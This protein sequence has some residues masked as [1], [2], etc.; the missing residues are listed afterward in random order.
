[1]GIRQLELDV[2]YFQK[3]LRIC[4]AGGIHLPTVEKVIH[5]LE[6]Y[7]N[8][9]IH[10]DPETIGCFRG[11][12][13]TLDDALQEIREWIVLPENNRELLIIYFDEQMDLERWDFVG[14]I[15][16][17]IHKHLHEYAFTL[18]MKRKLGNR[19]PTGIELIASGKR[20]LF[21]SRQNYK[22]NLREP[23][24]FLR[25]DL[26]EEFGPARF[27]QYPDCAPIA[28][29][30]T[31]P[32]VRI[33]GDSLWFSWFYRTQELIT[34]GLISEMNNCD[35][36]NVVSLD[37]AVPQLLEAFVWSW[38]KGQ[39]VTTGVC[40]VFTAQGRWEVAPSCELELFFACRNETNVYD[41]SLSITK[42]TARQ[43]VPTCP[44]GFS[45]SIP[46]SGGQNKHLQQIVGTKEPM[47]WVN[48][49]HLR[50]NTQTQTL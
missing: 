21:I 2:H 38:A 5:L 10:W 46:E 30:A 41:W 50:T 6:K 34:T 36:V 4:H 29:N 47:V 17:S 25:D 49:D 39:N 20:V 9:T 13:A 43:T 37:L 48:N 19:W 32:M 12:Y 26:W 8:K 42:G 28:S 23:Y 27:H 45:F 22:L 3:A 15:T 44:P 16:D 18:D 35:N 11:N 33:N 40:T 31:V 24:I 7:F 1:M 14:N